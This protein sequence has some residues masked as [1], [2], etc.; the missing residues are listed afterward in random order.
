MLLLWTLLSQLPHSAKF[1]P[2]TIR[3]RIIITP[4][5]F[6]SSPITVE[7]IQSL[8]TLAQLSSRVEQDRPAR[9][10]KARDGTYERR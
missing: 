9:D 2:E 1:L 5:T 6:L 10:E 3:L 7:R 8:Q 4:T